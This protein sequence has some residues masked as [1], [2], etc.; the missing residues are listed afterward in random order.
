MK[1]VK[2]ALVVLK[3]RKTVVNMFV[4]MGEIYKG[5]EVLIVSVSSAEEKTMMWY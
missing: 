3:V 4:L 5:A 2:G 1:I